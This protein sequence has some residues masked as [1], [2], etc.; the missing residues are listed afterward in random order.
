[1]RG[2]S[3]RL[4]RLCTGAIAA[5]ALALLPAGASAGTTTIITGTTSD[6]PGLTSTYVIEVP[7][8]WNGT[9]VLYSHGYSFTPSSATDAG[10]PVTHDWL[11]N[12]G[13]AIAGSSYSTPG[14]ALQQAFQDQIAVLDVFAKSKFGHPK[15]T[16]AWGHSLGGMIT[17]GLVQLYPKRFTAA[18]PMCGVVA[19]GLGS[20]N[21][22]LD[23]EFAFRTLL[24]P[25]VKIVGFDSFGDTLANFSVASAALAAAQASPQGRA[26]IALSAALADIPGWFDP[27][28]PQPTDY[29]T[30]ELNQFAW[31]TSIDFKFAFFGRAELEAPTRAGGNFSWNTGVDYRAQL[32]KSTDRAEVQALYKAAGLDLAKDLDTLNDAPRISAKPGPV[33]YVTRYI[34]YNGDLDM[35]V[36]TMHTTGD[37]LVSVT[38]EQA[39]ASVVKSAG[40]SSL[41][42]QVFVHRAGHCAFSP[43]ET[44]VAFQ[45]LVHRINTG[46]WSGTDPKGMNSQANAMGLAY[47]IVFIQNPGPPP[48]VS[49]VPEPASFLNFQPGQFLRPFDA[50][51]VGD[52]GESG[53]RD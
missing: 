36:L 21:Q 52:E 50:R 28:S 7:S 49:I 6:G 11:L 22:G 48:T 4:R 51:N 33:A 35:P 27:A 3:T 25:A 46:H 1:M 2:S 13:Y 40:D 23:S 53:N 47:N 14:W 5:V 39:Y 17:A 26:R 24:A 8:P 18:L 31:D 30:Q 20:W 16:I 38:D 42:R 37:G 43:A 15:R 45:T 9:L 19:G 32:A 29:A 44:I 12:N 41:L 10:D 34:T